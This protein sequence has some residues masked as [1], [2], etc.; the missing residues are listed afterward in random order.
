MEATLSRCRHQKPAELSRLAQS[1]GSH[2]DP[3]QPGRLDPW[4][5]RNGTLPTDKGIRALILET[6]DGVIQGISPFQY[7]GF[8][9]PG[10]PPFTTRPRSQS[11]GCS[12]QGYRISDL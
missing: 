10:V 4:G 11:Q 7:S 6:S 2:G 9:L 8:S 1:P 5:R 12:T 3:R